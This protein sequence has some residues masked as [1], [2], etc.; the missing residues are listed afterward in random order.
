MRHRGMKRLVAAVYIAFLAGILVYFQYAGPELAD[1]KASVIGAL[2]A[3]LGVPPAARALWLMWRGERTAEQ[4]T[5]VLEEAAKQLKVAVRNQW[6]AE[7]A[8][9]RINDPYP[10]PVAWRAADEELVAPW[11]ELGELALSWPGGPPGDPA[12]WPQDPAALGRQDGAIEKVFTDQIPTRRL[13]VL[14]GPGAGKSVLLIRLLQ[15]LLS[16]R[17]RDGPVPVI[18]SLASWDPHQALRTWLVGQLHHHYPGLRDTVRSP[19]SGTLG[20]L[21]GALWESGRILPLL[22]GFDELPERFQAAALDSLNRALPARSPLVLA[23]RLAAYRAAVD[24]PGPTLR[25]NGAAAIELLPLAREHAAAHLRRDAGGPHSSGASRWDAVIDQLGTESPVGQALST[26]L[27][28]YLARTIYN[29]RPGPGPRGTA[30]HPDELCERQ[31]FPDR[32]AVNRQLFQAFVHAAYAPDGPRPPRWSAAEAQRAFTFLARFQESRRLGSPDLAWWEL[33]GTVPKGIPCLLGGLL[34][35]ILF[36]ILG[37]IGGYSALKVLSPVV[38]GAAGAIMGWRTYGSAIR[39]C[40]FG[41][42]G[43]VVGGLAFV[44]GAVL[45]FLSPVFASPTAQY[46]PEGFV[47]GVVLGCL[48]FHPLG[49]FVVPSTVRQLREVLGGGLWGLAVILAV[50]VGHVLTGGGLEA[51]LTLGSLA[52]LVVS[53]F[54]PGRGITPRAPRP[55]SNPG[56]SK[57]LALDRREFLLVSVTFA[58]MAGTVFASVYNTPIGDEFGLGSA[59]GEVGLGLRIALGVV[60]GLATALVMGVVSATWPH[61]VIARTYL[62]LRGHLP[63][64]LMEFLRDAHENRGILRQ[65]GPVYQFRHIDLQRHLGRQH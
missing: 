41:A 60:T 53:M 10:L 32:T 30:P 57:L 7:S 5:A 19:I 65:V 52:G 31:D 35:G 23:S 46:V 42:I 64:D 27:G 8:L 37:F 22:D 14:G 61:F 45:G 55:T 48:T 33:R 25:L 6:D 17:D 56:A 29:P 54:W 62:A 9:R 38:G 24:G 15:D 21:A 12:L 13:V 59:M 36:G 3:L 43:I 39:T 18:F 20:D 11:N 49:R 51:L 47:T 26:P 40:L 28:I 34:L 63:R 58:L 16:D 2:I 44:L 1:Q 50:A 4:S